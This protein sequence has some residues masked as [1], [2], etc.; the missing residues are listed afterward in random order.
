M[1]AISNARV[2]TLGL[3]TD[4]AIESGRALITEH[5]GCI[6]VR[7]PL[8]PDHY[9][10]NF[11]IFDTPQRA[12][13]EDRWTALFEKI[14]GDDS[15]VRHA[16]FAWS[17]EEPPDVERFTQRGFAFQD[18]VVLTAGAIEHFDPPAGLA[19]RRF[20]CDND[21]NAQ[22]ELSLTT[23]E[24][25]HEEQAYARFMAAQIAYRREAADQF[26]AW[27]GAFDGEQL[28]GSCGIYSI[29]DGIARF[30]DVGVR[31]K[32]RNRGIARSL[33]SAAGRFANERFGA[34]QL[35]IVAD[36]DGAARRIYER[37]GFAPYQ[38]ECA[39]WIAAR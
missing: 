25:V 21:W 22:Y 30:Q 15:R 36:A 20:R 29:G 32:Y 16:A 27:L 10:G 11:L 31:P 26:G 8:N 23:R 35:V 7:T 1:P 13:D 18:R 19:V 24:T 3:R 28:A 9:F 33:V 39:L 12:G 17:A 6:S 34:S 37:C 4:L 5:A 2:R 38:R 14:F